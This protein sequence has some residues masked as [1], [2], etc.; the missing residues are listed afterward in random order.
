MTPSQ[1]TAAI[2]LIGNE[3]LSGRTQD[4]NLAFLAESLNVCGI[5]TLHA[6]VIPDI[7]ETIAASVNAVRTAYDYVFTT[8]GIGPTHDD[9]TTAS[10][11]QAF[12][13]RVLRHPEAEARL[14]AHYNHDAAIIN[15][16]RLKMADIPEGAELIANPVSAAPG[17]RLENVFVLAGVPR[18]CQA[19]FDEIRGSLAGGPP[20]LSR[21]LEI[22]L[23]E[24]TVAAAVT[25]I[26]ADFAADVEIGIYPLFR[27]GVLGA[28]LVLRA[29]DPSR[30]DAAFDA[31]RAATAQLGGEGVER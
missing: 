12:G 22:N 16:A 6:R 11:A 13:V 9:I 17:F 26:Q 23:P 18:I 1:R 19:M 8:G 30:L 20:T 24:G 28:T 3:I 7:E 5:R 31:A 15:D 4:K 29:I 10:V 21:A 14:R 25:Q 2:L 27:Q